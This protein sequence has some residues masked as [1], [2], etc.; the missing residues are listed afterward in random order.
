[1][2]YI[3]STWQ[4]T[5]ILFLVIFVSYVQFYK[6]AIRNSRRDGAAAITIELIGAGTLL[7]LI[8]LFDFKLPTNPLFWGLLFVS[9]AFYAIHDRIQTTARRN[10]PV[11]TFCVLDQISVV[12]LVI[13]GLTVFNE[14][15]SL[16][17]I[18]GGALIIFSNVLVFFEKGKITLNR[19]AIL[20]AVARIAYA[21]GVAIDIR[22]SEHFNFAFYI[23]LTLLVPAILIATF[24]KVGLSQIRA[25]LSGAAKRYF[26]IT[27][28]LFSLSVFF[29]IRSLQLGSV[30]VVA[31]LQATS[32]LLSVFI[33]WIVFK[34]EDD[35]AKKIAAAALA[36]AGICLTRL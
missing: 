36:V 26:I 16:I 18:L 15:L 25:E 27:G 9:G 30:S 35:I 10:L 17:K 22:T 11:S 6:L 5:L 2:Q 7:F 24:G 13:Y 14:P 28:I 23:M 34:E 8:P 20:V 32:V 29:S 4:G 33:A 12:V 19:Y 31:P 21:T 1:M 3:F